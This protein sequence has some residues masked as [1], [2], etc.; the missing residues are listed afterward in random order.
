MAELVA[1]LCSSKIILW[2]HGTWQQKSSMHDLR[3]FSLSA[4]SSTIS[5]LQVIAKRMIKYCSHVPFPHVCFVSDSSCCAHLCQNIYGTFICGCFPGY[6]CQNATCEEVDECQNGMNQCSENANCTNTPGSYMCSC[7]SG[8][9]GDGNNCTDINE[10]SSYSLHNC[11]YYAQCQNFEGGFSCTCRHG[12]TGSGSFCED[13]NECANG[14][15]ACSENANCH[16]YNGGYYCTC[17][18]GFT[19][20][21]RN[22]TDI[23][24]CGEE[25]FD[26]A[27]PLHARDFHL[28]VAV[29]VRHG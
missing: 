4:K 27:L 29:T 3:L 13:L 18:P 7:L 9:S 25:F 5:Y 20:N 2:T 26:T 21:G 14:T 10:C 23:D 1:F 12:Y 22:C 19:G 24:E 28:I 8:Y 6:A 11:H 16:N 17:N 15:N